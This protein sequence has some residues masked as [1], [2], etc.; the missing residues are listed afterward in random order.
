MQGA[1]GGA[2]HS[3]VAHEVLEDEEVGTRELFDNGTACL[4]VLT[5]LDAARAGR[6]EGERR[7]GE[8][9]WPMECAKDYM[10]AHGV[11]GNVFRW[12]FVKPDT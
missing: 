1:Q 11:T 12:L 9:G 5:R 2:D 7:E 3:E 10:S 6:G 4:G 8:V